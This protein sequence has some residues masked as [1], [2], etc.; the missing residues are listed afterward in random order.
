MQNP[1]WIGRDLFGLLGEQN[2]LNREY[3]A[4]MVQCIND[5]I[6][7]LNRKVLRAVTIQEISTSHDID[8]QGKL[9]SQVQI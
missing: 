2:F 5:H 4:E 9:D 7:K 3:P 8:R 1:H 6:P